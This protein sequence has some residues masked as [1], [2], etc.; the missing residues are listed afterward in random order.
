MHPT[1]L[2]YCFDLAQVRHVLASNSDLPWLPF[3]ICVSGKWFMS[4]K[5]ELHGPPPFVPLH[6]LLIVLF[7][8]Q[9][10]LVTMSCLW[11]LYDFDFGVYLFNENVRDR[12]KG[13]KALKFMVFFNYEQNGIEVLFH[14]KWAMRLGKSSFWLQKLVCLKLL[15]LWTSCCI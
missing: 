2:C 10:S 11:G 6:P 7:T 12:N 3:P 15:G 8:W 13:R 1:V 14:S 4:F 5:S 9:V